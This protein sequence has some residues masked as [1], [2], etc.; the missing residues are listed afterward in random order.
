MGLGRYYIGSL[1]RVIE[2]FFLS[3]EKTTTCIYLKYWHILQLRNPNLSKKIKKMLS[4]TTFP[5]YRQNDMMDCGPTCL[6]MISKHYGKFFNIDKIRKLSDIGKT[7]VSLLGITKA[8]ES[9]GIRAVGGKIPFETI[10]KAGALPCIVHWKKNHFLI[11]YKVSKNKVYVSDPASGLG[12]YS[13]NDFIE[14]WAFTSNNNSPIGI[15]LFLQP[16]P[17][18]YLQ[19]ESVQK[20]PSVGL[21]YLWA[22]IWHYKKL[23]IQLLIGVLAASIIQLIFP[24]LTKSLIDVGIKNQSFQLITLILIGQLMLS[25]GQFFIELV[26]GWVLLH[27][28]SR[29]NISIISDFLHKLM[30]LPLSFFDTKLTG[31]ILQ[32]I[33]DHKRI[34]VLL[35]G[36]SLSTIFSFFNLVIFSALIV[37]YSPIIFI[38]FISGSSVYFLWMLYFLK[39]RKQLDFKKFEARAQN[40]SKILQIINGI[41]EIK[42]ND[43]GTPKIWDWERVQARLFKLN[44]KSLTLEQYQK[45]GALLINQAKDIVIIY[46]AA[47]SVLKGELSLGDMMA[48]QFIIGQMN[49]PISQMAGFM[50]IAQDAKISIERIGQIHEIDNEES[51]IKGYQRA[52]PSDRG[53]QLE[54]VSFAYSGAGNNYIIKDLNL[55]IPEGRVTAI[56]GTSG[57]GKTTL[58]KL[59]LR[60]YNPSSGRITVGDLV[61]FNTISPSYW[62]EKC[63]VVMQDGFIFSDSILNNIVMGDENIDK[64]KL[65]RALHV[66]N[67]TEFISNL[68]LGLNTKIGTDGKGTSGGQ[69][70][71][72]LIARVVYKDP[73]YIF[74]DEATSALDANNEKAIIERLNSFYEGKTVMVVAHRLSTVK[75]ADKIIV[76]NKSTIVEEGKHLDLVARKGYYYELI[77]NQLDLGE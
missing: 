52:L 30:K 56:V 37:Y 60:I 31:D 47:M 67:L 54:N 75:N 16:T 57:S 10:S 65:S 32:R 29:V 50:Q 73:E 55:V 63:G 33:E 66:A 8:A 14:N 58:L 39:R 77:K 41:Q 61:D 40:Q 71:R 43:S 13:K 64:D 38:V 36:N 12:K 44:I 21:N 59:L 27:I 72:I 6:L 53:L 19:E 74:L 25:I 22:N 69:K 46:L 1:W 48:I 9:I 5:N 2:Y 17:E 68:P 23:V 42:I 76:L 4:T 3:R 45:T 62:R 34:E 20:S 11:V 70:Q 18:F 15:A 7:G 51:E 24:L 49:S 35:T 26:R 28:T